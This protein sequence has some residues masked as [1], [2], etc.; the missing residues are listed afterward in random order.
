MERIEWAL[1]RLGRLPLSSL[2]IA[3][4]LALMIAL[5]I[6]DPEP[7]ARLRLSAFDTFLQLSPREADPAFP[8]KVVEI[9]EASLKEVGQWPWPRNILARLVERL[10]DAGAKVIALDIV[11]PEADRLS[12]KEFAKAY[13]GEPAFSQVA[14]EVSALPTLDT[15]LA[16]AL[17]H[18]PSIL[19]F[20]GED[21][22]QGDPGPAR[23][24]FVIAGDPPEQF[25]PGF[26]GSVANLSELSKAAQ[27]LG[28]A[29]WIP[30]RDRI[31]RRVPLLIRVGETLYPSL[32][33]EALRVGLGDS[34]ILIKS[35]GSSGIGAF[36]YQTGIELLRTGRVVIPTNARGELWLRLSPADS[37]RKISAYKVLRDD[38]DP[39][40]VAGRFVFVGA[41]AIGLLDIQGT[42]LDSTAAGV[43]MHAQALEQMLAGEHAVRPAYATGL[44]IFLLL[45][46]GAVV[47]WLLARAGP[48]TAVGIGLLGI[49]AVTVG[50]YLAYKWQ[51]LLIDPV[52]PSLSLALVYGAGSLTNFV[53]AERERR[54]IRSAFANYLAP[55]LVEELVAHPEKLRLGG[56]MREVTLLFADV[57]QFSAIAERLDAESL[58]TF[59]NRLFT[60]LS[61]AI[62][63]ERGTIDKFMGDA[64]MAFWN[65]PIADPRHAERASRAAL[66]MLREL[67]V[68]NATLALEAESAGRTFTPIRIGIGLNTGI[69]CVGNVGSPERFDYS[70]LGDVVNVASRFEALT[71]TY[72]TPIV[73][74][75]RTAKAAPGLAFLEIDDVIP[76]GRTLAEPI[77]ALI[78]DETVAQSKL[79][80]SLVPLHN[81][82][83][84]AVTSGD[85]ERVCEA[86]AEC[87]RVG[88]ATYQPL[89]RFFAARAKRD[90]Q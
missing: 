38:F 63:E 20:A 9:D 67:E 36:G 39:K 54:R 90:L 33:I 23:A 41:T 77:Y 21:G 24:S 19:T 69:A 28:A 68:L 40:E 27:G 16:E 64:V 82:L 7:I 31:V 47:A 59:V 22:G 65:A 42:P 51:G 86:L 75:E 18:S 46:L 5:R 50:T 34:T 11:L 78:G 6:A 61:E 62:I 57:R 44:E 15:Q 29:N 84:E 60:P 45:V 89:L 10:S 3:G 35:S 30:E 55:D 80:K 48:L 72:D 73:A 53:R 76:R 58:V 1:A 13:S 71:K 56:E 79:F 4:G 87:R 66:R 14:G 85:A 70:V 26:K 25:V 52:Y 32:A 17:A 83:R 88:L 37:R 43:V 8:V 49:L 2:V 81:G 74:G 12:P